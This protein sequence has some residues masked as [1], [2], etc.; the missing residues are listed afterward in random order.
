[1]LEMVSNFAQGVFH[2]EVNG[3][4][5]QKNSQKYRYGMVLAVCA[6]YCATYSNMCHLAR[7]ATGQR[8]IYFSE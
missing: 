7:T 5:Q 3:L 1:M 2:I 8:L 4:Q 6:S